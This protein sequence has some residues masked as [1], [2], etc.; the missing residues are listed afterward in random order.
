MASQSISIL[1]FKVKS[2][3]RSTFLNFR[4]HSNLTSWWSQCPGTLCFP[5][6]LSKKV[7][8]EISYRRCS[9]LL[10]SS[11]DEYAE[12]V[13]ETEIV[14]TLKVVDASSDTG[15]MESENVPLLHRFLKW[16]LWVFGPII[17]L[18]TG[19]IPTLWL[20]LSSIFAA[21]NIS[22]LLS[23]VGLDCIFNMGA[24]SFLLIS[25]ACAKIPGTVSEPESTRLHYQVPLLYKSWNIL[26][27]FVGLVIPL[28]TFYLGYRGFLTPSIPVI[29]FA[30]VIAPY[31]LLLVVQMVTEMLTW[32]W[33]SP[34]W[35]VVPVVYEGYRIV[36]LMRGLKLGIEIGAPD[37]VV[38]TIRG[39]VSWWVLVF[40]VQLM[41]IA[42]FT[43]YT[44]NTDTSP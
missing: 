28:A 42:W 10:C 11:E 3:N 43:G 44:I 17:L 36:Q 8:S 5:M 35:I 37:W 33:K 38:V 21:A 24:M 41:R 22:G 12:P 6:K 40:G 18:V 9:I 32:H 23:L 2:M 34:A 7:S 29:D 14:E 15:M 25:D 19:I 13:N 4:N 16:P 1:N 30:V 20:P 39:L 27:G 31:I 26:A